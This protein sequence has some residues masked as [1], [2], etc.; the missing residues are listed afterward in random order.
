MFVNV[1]DYWP[2]GLAGTDKRLRFDYSTSDGSLD[3]ISSVFWW[4]RKR[5]SLI[6]SDYDHTGA[7]KDDWEL[8]HV[9]GWGVAEIAD[10]YPQTGFLAKLFGPVRALRF[11]EKEW[12]GWGDVVE[13]GKAYANEP[14]VDPFASRPP[15]FGGCKQAITY[16]ILLDSFGTRHGDI[17]SNV[18]VQTY[19]QVWGTKAT[20][21]RYWMARDI[22]P[23]AI[24]WVG[25]IPDEVKYLGVDHS[26]IHLVQSSRLDAVVT[27]QALAA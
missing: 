13:L 22:G 14:K 20:G 26:K 12:I 19:L 2:F 16:D 3:P 27:G 4:D 9:P 17:W 15:Q 25:V 7:W 24:Q 21:A 8:R 11:R 23:V 6:Y 5:E 18:L 10:Y 1:K